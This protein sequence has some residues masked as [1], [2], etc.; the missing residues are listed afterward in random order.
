MKVILLGDIDRVGKA[1][2][3]VEVSEGFSRNFLF[4]Q[5]KAMP[6]SSGA[7]KQYEERKRAI[8]KRQAD[9]RQEAEALALRL[10]DL[11]VAIKANVGEEGKLF[12]SIT[13]HDI[14]KGLEQMGF[15][16]ERKQIE[17]AAPFRE[18]G[19]YPVTIR[20]YP[21]VEAVI[22]VSIS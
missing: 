5:K 10:K 13:P 18:V 4:P 3:I 6:V 17:L 16:I 11:T 7:L 15:K 20:V 9:H 12:G 19:V 1:G 22:Q 2:E 14:Q 8:A 21:E